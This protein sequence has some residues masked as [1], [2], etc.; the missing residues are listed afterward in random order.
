MQHLAKTFSIAIPV[1]D[2]CQ[3][4]SRVDGFS[5]IQS[6]WNG[7]NGSNYLG[8]RGIPKNRKKNINDIVNFSKQKKKCWKIF[9]K[10]DHFFEPKVS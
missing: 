2:L 3:Q 4:N 1:Q 8:I 6:E 10:D 7:W 5:K 9:L